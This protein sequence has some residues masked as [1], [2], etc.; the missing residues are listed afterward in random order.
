M[1]TQSILRA[2]LVPALTFGLILCMFADTG[3]PGK[4]KHRAMYVADVS[5]TIAA[6]GAFSCYDLLLFPGGKFAIVHSTDDSKLT[7][8]IGTWYVQSGGRM[9]ILDYYDGTVD[10]FTFTGDDM[11]YLNI[12]DES[13]KLF[14]HQW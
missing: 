3:K 9:L 6:D 7:E 13:N 14:F 10:Y 1:F 8:V 11:T 12:N 4:N 5:Y 2:A